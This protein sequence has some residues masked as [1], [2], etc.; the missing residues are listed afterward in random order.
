MFSMFDKCARNQESTNLEQLAC[1]EIRIANLGNCNYMN[2]AKMGMSGET[3][4]LQ[5]RNK[6]TK[7]QSNITATC[8]YLS[9]FIFFLS[10]SKNCLI[11]ASLTK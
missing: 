7:N 11:C 2:Y 4:P 5:F 9:S 3:N 6:V 1:T 10:F 8:F